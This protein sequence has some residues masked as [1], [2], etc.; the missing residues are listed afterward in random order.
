MKCHDIQAWP[1]HRVSE[2]QCCALLAGERGLP[3]A[4]Q[5]EMS[6]VTGALKRA[7]RQA[8]APGMSKL[9]LSWQACAGA[10]MEQCAHVLVGHTFVQ[11]L[12]CMGHAAH[13]QGQRLGRL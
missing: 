6:A 8:S 4:V 10:R 9:Q 1:D 3:A 5:S 13:S 2:C 7:F 11:I 12:L